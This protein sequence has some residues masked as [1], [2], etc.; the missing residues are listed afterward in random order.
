MNYTKFNPLFFRL[1]IKD[2]VRSTDWHEESLKTEVDVYS[3]HPEDP[4]EEKKNRR[5]FGR[6]RKNALNRRSIHTED[7]PEDP[8]KEEEKNG[9]KRFFGRMRKHALNRNS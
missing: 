6:M 5:V 1:H 4:D 2:A 8:D 3:I 7:H 9:K